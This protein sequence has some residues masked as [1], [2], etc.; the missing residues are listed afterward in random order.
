[1][2][3]L[4]WY[5]KCEQTRKFVEVTYVYVIDYAHDSMTN[6]IASLQVLEFIGFYA[7]WYI[8]QFKNI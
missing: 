7:W 8:F 1:M 6:N 3:K 5:V 2:K 4:M